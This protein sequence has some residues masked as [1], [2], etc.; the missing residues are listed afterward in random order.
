MTK[1]EVFYDYACPFCFKGHQNLTELLPDFPQIEV[2]WHP[3]ETHPRPEQYGV[4]S[5]LLIQGMFY[6][7]D[8]GVDL[9]QYHER[10]YNL[11]WKDSQNVENIDVLVSGFADLLDVDSFAEALTSNKY[12]EIQ[13]SSNDYAFEKSGVWVVPAYR[14]GGNKLDSVAGVGVT[15]SQFKRFLEEAK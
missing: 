6:A 2:V 12:R 15:K 4:H 9:W 11:I 1:I 5:D 7:A 3:C 10:A 8:A 13:Q 14:M